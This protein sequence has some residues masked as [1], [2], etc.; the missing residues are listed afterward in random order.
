MGTSQAYGYADSVVKGW[1]SLDVA[2]LGHL[3]S[4]H[5]PPIP[6][7]MVPVA[8]RAIS[9]IREGVQEELID[10]PGGVISERHGSKVPAHAVAD[11][12]NLWAFVQYFEDCNWHPD[13]EYTDHDLAA[14]AYY[15]SGET[16][17]IVNFDALREV[18][19]ERADN[20]GDLAAFVDWIRKHPEELAE[21]L[22]QEHGDRLILETDN[23]PAE[24]AELRELLKTFVSDNG[25]SA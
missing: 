19:K 16:G 10:L 1:A 9:L 5:Y 14:V 7:Y 24:R 23:T 22:V 12:L 25:E 2:L 20:Y 8:K 11:D 17:E 3:Q 15:I 13:P 18:V 4:N 21:S 6:A